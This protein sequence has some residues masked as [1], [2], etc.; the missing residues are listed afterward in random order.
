MTSTGPRRVAVRRTGGFAGLTRSGELDLDTD[1]AG[2]EVRDLLAGV[3]LD[4]LTA[5]R[6]GPDRFVYTV[7]YGASQ[8]TLPEQDLTPELQRVVKIVLGQG[9][10]LPEGS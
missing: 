7:D 1:P 9:A 4:A 2:A 10:R 5:S 3:D 6:S 8:V